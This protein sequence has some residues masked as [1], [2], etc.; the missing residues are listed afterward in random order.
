MGFIDLFYI[1]DWGDP[2]GK[3]LDVFIPS[4]KVIFGKY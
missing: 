2:R 3:V 4:G 1:A